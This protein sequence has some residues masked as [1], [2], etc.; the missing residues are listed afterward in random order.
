MGPSKLTGRV[1]GLSS[2]RSALRLRLDE[3]FAGDVS[4]PERK[5][6]QC[7]ENYRS[8]WKMRLEFCCR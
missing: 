1:K 8:W 3:R 4:K 6:T 7:A 2:A 5:V